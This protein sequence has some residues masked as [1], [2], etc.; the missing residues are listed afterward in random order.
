MSDVSAQPSH[1]VEPLAQDAIA[2]RLSAEQIQA[3]IAEMACEINAAY[4]G[5]QR[6]TLI[7]ILKGS[8]LFLADLAR[9]L[10]MPCQIEFVRLASYGDQTRSSGAVKP[11]DLTLPNLENADVLIVED[12]MDTG[13]TLRFF[14]EYLRSLHHTRSLKLAVLLDKPETRSEEARHLSID[15]CG[16]TVQN[17][18]LV[19]YGLDYAGLYRNLPFVGVLPTP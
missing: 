15:F 8:F 3:R 4:A 17:E 18:F 16:F 10:T 2:V 5:C 1:A 14:M 13:L 7:A 12:I 9:H 6:L 19:G 11:V